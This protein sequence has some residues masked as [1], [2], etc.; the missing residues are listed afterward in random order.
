MKE[1]CFGALRSRIQIGS[2]VLL[3]QI[4]KINV[5]FFGA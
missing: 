2:P 3:R 4:A 5:A 1:E